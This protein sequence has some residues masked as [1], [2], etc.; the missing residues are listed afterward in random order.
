MRIARYAADDVIHYGVVELSGDG[1]KYPETASDLSGDPI[2]GSVAL[3]GVRRDL[4][5]VRLLAPVLP[6]SK[7]I[8]VIKPPVGHEDKVSFFIKPNTSVIGPGEPIHIPSLSHAT[9]AEAELA[10][11]ISRICRSVPPSRVGEVIFGYTAAN[12]VTATDLKLDGAPW[13][14]MKSWDNFT[15]LGP[16]IMTHLSVEEASNL[17]VSAR[18]DGNTVTQANT[19]NLPHSI[20]ELICH[21]SSVMTLLPSDVIL[22]SAP[23]GPT[24]IEEG[25]TVSIEISEIGALTNPV[26]K[27]GE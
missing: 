23:G 8:G 24:P 7:V 11:V 20:V 5:D 1:G 2:A 4:G 19:K 25:Q 13:G 15:P 22:T 27:E 17:D 10:V 12:D 6:R 14:M 3:T 16:W 9:A 21:L 18:V 26:I